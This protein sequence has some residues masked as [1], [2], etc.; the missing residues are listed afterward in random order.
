MAQG[1]VWGVN[2]KEAEPCAGQKKRRLKPKGEEGEAPVRIRGEPDT[3]TY[4]P[5]KGL[6]SFEKLKL[7]FFWGSPVSEHS[8]T[9]NRLR[10]ARE[11]IRC[12]VPCDFRNRQSLPNNVF[13]APMALVGPGGRAS[14]AMALPSELIRFGGESGILESGVAI[15]HHLCT[16]GGLGRSE[17]A[18]AFER[19]GCRVSGG[20]KRKHF[21]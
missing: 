5:E 11:C 10:L 2:P 6:F 1:R 19:P 14:Y 21:E 16:C 13:P 15:G 20:S 3:L 7:S 9:T 12:P 8:G 17:A 4:D 18:E